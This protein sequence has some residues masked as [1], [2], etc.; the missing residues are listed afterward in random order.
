MQKSARDVSYSSLTIIAGS[1]LTLKA[2]CFLQTRKDGQWMTR[3]GTVA[4]RLTELGSLEI[5]QVSLCCI[6]V[7]NFG[8]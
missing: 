7:A 2:P 1:G 3:E 4:H 6:P 8:S 5:D